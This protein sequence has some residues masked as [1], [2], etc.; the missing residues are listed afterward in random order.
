MQTQHDFTPK[1]LE[2]RTTNKRLTA[3]AGLG[4]LLEAFDQ[5]KLTKPFTKALPSR[6]SCRSQ[7]SYRLGLI[8][9]ASFMRGHD[10]LADLEEFRKDPMLCEVM[11]GETVAPRTMGDFLRDFESENLVDFNSFLSLQA[12]AYRVQLEKM[13]KKAFKPSLAPHLRIDSTSHVQHGRKMEGLGYNY[14]DEWCLDSQV[15]F[16]ELG[17]CWDLELRPGSTKSG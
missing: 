16:D 17:F 10:C 3:A 7:G 15:I 12:K 5:S 13:L 8:Q 2:F 11:K 9:M 14:K 1:F 6:S 4:I